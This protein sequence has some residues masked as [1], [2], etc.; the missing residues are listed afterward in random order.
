LRREPH[1]SHFTLGQAVEV[2]EDLGPRR[3]YL[4]HIS[5]QLGRHREVEAELPSWI[6]LA[7]DGLKIE[8]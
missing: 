2:L 5:H 1:I 8:V 6:R 7:Y 4:T 3:A